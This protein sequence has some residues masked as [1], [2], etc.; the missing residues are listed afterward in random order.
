ML[1][2]MDRA[3]SRR[4]RRANT[5]WWIGEKAVVADNGLTYLVYVTDVGEIHIQSFSAKSRR[6]PTEDRCLCRLN[7]TYGDEH[8]APSLC[9]TREGYLIVLYTGHN[10]GS[11]LYCRVS[12]RPYDIDSFGPEQ[13]LPYDGRVT[14]AQ[15]FENTARGEIW[16]FTRVNSTT[17]QFRRSADRCANWSEPVLLLSSDQGGLYYMTMR[18]LLV[19][20]DAG[21]AERWF[22]AVYGH[23][24][25]SKDH[26]VR[27]GLLDEAGRV[28]RCDGSDT[29]RSLF[30]TASPVLE[31]PELEIAYETPETESV[32]L[33]AV[34][35]TEPLRVAIAA[36][37]DKTY[38]RADYRIL[39]FREGR[40]QLSA[41]LCENLECLAPG[42]TD[43]SQTY[44]GGMEFYFG[45]GDAALCELHGSDNDTD[46]VF[47]AY[48]GP[49]DWI[50]ESYVTHDGG[51]AYPSE[52]VIRRIP[53]STGRKLWRPTVPAFA[54]DNLP[55]YWHE[56][57]YTAHTGGWH[58]D[59]HM[60]IDYDD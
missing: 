45:A 9:V 29:G 33:L 48:R 39:R 8:N 5:D 4:I 12:A 57:T 49:S 32:R 47:A 13:V 28:L 38:A 55:V 40:W 19:P 59:V 2:P 18:R 52:Q 10:S 6:I 23:P 3:V 20:T 15:V 50:L 53:A 54:Q 51:R 30:G 37:P 56:G 42:Q 31:I 35:P 24:V 58:C 22:F 7:T 36:F 16:L 26:T 11:C 14:Y 34:S 60:L 17:W 44:V 21:A 43:G 46:R 27:C 41:P 1:I 25:I